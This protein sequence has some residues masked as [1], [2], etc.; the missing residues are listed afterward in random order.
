VVTLE[1]KRNAS[2]LSTTYLAHPLWWWDRT[3]NTFGGCK[4]HSPG[5]LLCYAAAD[6][7]TVQQ[8]SGRERQVALLYDGVV[9]RVKDGFIFNGTQTVLPPWHPGWNMPLT[10][11][12][13]EV[14]LLGPGKPSLIFVASMSEPFLAGRPQ[15]VLDRTFGT[16]A[17]S[18]HVGQVLT[19]NPSRM[20]EYF[21]ALDSRTVRRWQPRFWLGFSA[22]RQQEFDLRWP[23]MRQLAAR[24]W[25]AFV[26]IAPMLGPVVLP[27]DLLALGDRAWVIISGEQ[28]R[29]HDRCRPM[30]VAWVSP[31]KKQCGDA[32]VPLFVKQWAQLAPIRP[33]FFIHQFPAVAP[34][35]KSNN[36]AD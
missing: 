33:D 28:G 17:M 14:P 29:P 16:V 18:K 31:V 5:C 22:E 21:T 9:D 15:A 20:A 24:G 26:S 36:N 10:W 3:Y 19:K 12:G 2:A 32:G 1:L 25:T 30:D 11:P 27:P 7:G 35:K 8:E 4:Y 6:A 23:Y 34:L 13:A